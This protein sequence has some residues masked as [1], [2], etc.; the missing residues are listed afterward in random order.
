MSIT[1]SDNV[2]QRSTAAAQTRPAKTKWQELL[3]ANKH[4]PVLY[5]K[6]DEEKKKYIPA[7][8]EDWQHAVPAYELVRKQYAQSSAYWEITELIKPLIGAVDRIV[9]IGLGCPSGG[10][11]G[12]FAQVAMLSHI[13]GMLRSGLDEER[14][15]TFRSLCSDYNSDEQSQDFLQN[16]CN[17][18]SI[19]YDYDGVDKSLP[20]EITMLVQGRECDIPVFSAKS[21]VDYLEEHITPTTLLF[22]PNLP[23]SPAL[24]IV[25][26][27]PPAVVITNHLEFFLGGIFQNEHATGEA[28]KAYEKQFESEKQGYEKLRDEYQRKTLGLCIEG[29]PKRDKF[30]AYVPIGDKTREGWTT[31]GKGLDFD[32]EESEENLIANFE[33]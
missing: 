7:T 28:A 20:D 29:L 3:D 33:G 27:N 32:V 19:E 22:M 9:T 11:R 13:A 30:S 2:S 8:Y 26:A 6:Y 4:R 5:R 15:K 14:K 18:C 17:I 12:I 16:A 21:T 31:G 1:N 24:R 10:D 25:G 23:F